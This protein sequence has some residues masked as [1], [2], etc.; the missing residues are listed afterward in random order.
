MPSLR[1]GSVSRSY[2]EYRIGNSD[3]EFYVRTDR[4]GIITE[5]TCQQA[6][7]FMGKPLQLFHRWLL[8]QASDKSYGIILEML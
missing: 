2:Y 1:N 6:R 3:Q 8:E 7:S 4:F 5:G